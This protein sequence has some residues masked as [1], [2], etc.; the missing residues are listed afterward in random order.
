MVPSTSA[1]VEL[2]RVAF[3]EQVTE[4][5]A[6]CGY[7]VSPIGGEGSLVRLRRTEAGAWVVV[8][9]HRVWMS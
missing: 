6:Y 2:S 5:L 7:T 4:A 9:W 3:N 8:A 1:L